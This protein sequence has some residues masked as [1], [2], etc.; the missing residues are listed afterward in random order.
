MMSGIETL[1]V[2]GLKEHFVTAAVLAAWEALGPRWQDLAL[3]PLSDDATGHRF[4]D[5]GSDRRAA[6]ADVDEICQ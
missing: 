5:L 3:M 2:I 6:M 1:K 4:A